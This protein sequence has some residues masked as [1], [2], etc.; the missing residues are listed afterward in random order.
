MGTNDPSRIEVLGL[1]LKEAIYP[2]DSAAA[3]SRMKND[4]ASNESMVV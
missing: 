4:K 1:T 3:R 2:F